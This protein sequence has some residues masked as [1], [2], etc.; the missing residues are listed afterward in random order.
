[1]AKAFTEKD[2]ARETEALEVLKALG[3]RVTFHAMRQK[4]DADPL[5]GIEAHWRPGECYAVMYAAD[6]RRKSISGSS[7]VGVL[8]QARSWVDWQGQLK[9]DAANKFVP[10][11]DNSPTS[12]TVVV[13]RVA[14]DKAEV[15]QRRA[16]TERRLLNFES[17]TP[18]LVD[19]HGDPINA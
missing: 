19:A 5:L 14:G 18:R 13:H 4:V 10:S 1:M 17:S 2:E 11:A 16:N 12:E 9:P 3:F 8:T 7:A 15:A 6:G